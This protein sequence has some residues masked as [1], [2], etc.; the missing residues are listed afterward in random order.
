MTIDI[1]EV[2][3]MVKKN[4][5]PLLSPVSPT[6][7]IKEAKHNL[8]VPF[9]FKG[10]LPTLHLADLEID[11]FVSE[12]R[13]W[14]LTPPS[15]CTNIAIRVV[16][17]ILDEEKNIGAILWIALGK[18]QHGTVIGTVHHSTVHW[19]YGKIA[20]ME[21]MWCAHKAHGEGKL[22]SFFRGSGW[23]EEFEKI[24]DQMSSDDKN[25]ECSCPES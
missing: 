18:C 22:R 14:V 7:A 23:E 21:N 2:K 24:L 3:H 10:D 6:E 9:G 25:I 1:E 11:T 12:L 5:E 19:K 16:K 15:D 13:K 17:H 8:F 20:R 4:L